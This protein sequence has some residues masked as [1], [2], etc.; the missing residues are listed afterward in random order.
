MILVGDYFEKRFDT[1]Q[2]VQKYNMVFATLFAKLF[3]ANS[4]RTG[5]PFYNRSV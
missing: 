4:V 3:F 1:R 5:R 2:C